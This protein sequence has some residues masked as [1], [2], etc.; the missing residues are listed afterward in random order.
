MLLIVS[1]ETNF[2]GDFNRYSNM[3]IEENAFES[4]VCEMVT[5]LSMPQ[6]FTNSGKI[7]FLPVN[8]V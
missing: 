5:N 7:V 2:S 3:F 8:A 1:L 6:C 4:V